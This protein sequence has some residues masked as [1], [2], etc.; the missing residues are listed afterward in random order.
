MDNLTP[1][2]VWLN[3]YLVNMIEI[4]LGSPLEMDKR[5][6]IS[7]SGLTPVPII[8]THLLRNYKMLPNMHEMLPT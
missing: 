6:S 3:L 7:P 4:S 2:K 1:V 8:S 5:A